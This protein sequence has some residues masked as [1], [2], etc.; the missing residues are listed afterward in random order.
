MSDDMENRPDLKR[1]LREASEG[2]R[3]DL[4]AKLPYEVG[5]GK[6]PARSR[7]KRGQSGNRK[8]RPKGRPNVAT[9]IEKELYEAVE[10]ND[11]GR[12]RKMPKIQIGIRQLMN[13]AAAGDPKAI[14]AQIDLAHKLGKFKDAPVQAAPAVDP[15]DLQALGSALSLFQTAF[16]IDSADNDE[17]KT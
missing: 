11:G 2:E 3:A 12:R 13:K 6:P 14:A 15:R 4:I 8:G 5:F 17:D 7:F 10:V 1:Q 9:M 16:T